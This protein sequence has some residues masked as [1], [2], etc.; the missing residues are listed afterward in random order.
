MTWL[1]DQVLLAE[2]SRLQ[3]ALDPVPET[4]L[5]AAELAGA[6]VDIDWLVALPEPLLRAE[7]VHRLRFG[8][9]G[10][11]AAVNLEVR[12]PTVAGLAPPLAEL[13]LHWRGGRGTVALDEV[14]Y[15]RFT[16]VPAGPL[17]VVL[18]EAGRAPRATRWFT[19]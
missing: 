8:R 14:G 5:A 15:F 18:V 11:P 2:L 10:E 13:T 12:L 6:L 16:D 7:G 19:P 4:V 9:A 17:R 3:Q 1:S